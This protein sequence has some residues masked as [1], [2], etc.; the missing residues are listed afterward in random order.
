MYQQRTSEMIEALN[1]SQSEK[2]IEALQQKLLTL[3][4]LSFTDTINS[5]A[6][7]NDYRLRSLGDR[8]TDSDLLLDQTVFDQYNYFRTDLL[9]RSSI[10]AV[11]LLKNSLNLDFNNTYITTEIENKSR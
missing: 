8:S 10:S 7:E 4:D 1:N 6:I 11:K 9:V 2:V 3:G 5:N